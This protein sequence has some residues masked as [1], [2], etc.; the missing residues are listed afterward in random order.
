MSRGMANLGTSLTWST[1]WPCLKGGVFV[2]QER[3]NRLNET[4]HVR[5]L[6]VSFGAALV[7]KSPCARSLVAF[8]RFACVTGVVVWVGRVG[9]SEIDQAFGSWRRRGICYSS[10]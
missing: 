2:A 8:L 9:G 7:L 6:S 10:E 4:R 5:V 1:R 3:L